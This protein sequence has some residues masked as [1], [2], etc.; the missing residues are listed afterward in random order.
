MTL[1]LGEQVIDTIAAD[2]TERETGARNVDAVINAELMPVLSNKIL[3]QMAVGPLP[4]QVSVGVDAD[5]QFTFT[6]SGAS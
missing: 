5:G 3:E 2:C 6:F 1:D 4:K